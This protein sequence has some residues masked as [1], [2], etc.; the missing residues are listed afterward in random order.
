M[1]VDSPWGH[2]IYTIIRSVFL[3]TDYVMLLMF[4]SKSYRRIAL[5]IIPGILLACLVAILERP[6]EVGQW[7]TILISVDIGAGL[8]SNATSLTR[9][10]WVNVKITHKHLFIIFHLF[11]YPLII[12]NISKK[13]VV[14]SILLILL[15]IKTTYFI[16]GQWG[17]LGRS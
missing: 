3:Y 5:L 13:L 12:I 11:I 6:R 2:K 14:T 17:Y 15:F 16:K 9:L 4:G 8:V 7:L 10:A 1:R